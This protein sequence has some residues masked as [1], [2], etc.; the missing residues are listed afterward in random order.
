MD[1]KI[2]NHPPHSPDLFP[3]DIHMFRP[4]KNHLEQKF[5][6]ADEK[7]GGPETGYAVRIMLLASVIFH[8]GKNVLM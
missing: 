8:D 7:T 1:W 6:T 5:K 2:M 4:L 3:S